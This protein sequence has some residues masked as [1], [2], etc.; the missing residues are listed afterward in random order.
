MYRKQDSSGMRVYRHKCS[1]I[2]TAIRE[3]LQSALS[4]KLYAADHH[5]PLCHWQHGT[6]LVLH[7]DCPSKE[8]HVNN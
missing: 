3:T 2:A 4:K 7:G 5:I 1:G 6:L 8:N